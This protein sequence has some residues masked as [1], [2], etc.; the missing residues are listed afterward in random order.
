MR[1]F[2]S[3]FILPNFQWKLI[4][5]GTLP[6]IAS[7][8][9]LYIQFNKSF[10]R[11]DNHMRILGID[12]NLQVLSA[13]QAQEYLL[14][15]YFLIGAGIAIVFMLIALVI[16]S[17]KLAGPIYRL[18]KELKKARE[19]GEIHP[20]YF[21]ENDYLLDIEEDLNFCLNHN[22]DVNKAS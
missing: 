20:I 6:V 5:W 15:K 11:L 2:K 10:D 19:T 17:H 18:K 12:K 4:F 22:D 1:S 3:F 9:F 7:F 16:V 14:H 8:I 13:V 21:R